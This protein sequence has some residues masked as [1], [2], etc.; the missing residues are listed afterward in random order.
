VA[1]GVALLQAAAALACRIPDVR[2]FPFPPPEVPPPRVDPILTRLHRADI[3]I[4]GDVAKVEVAATFYNPNGFR[5]EG[6]YFFPIEADAVVKDFTM[7]V[8]GKDQKAE[9]LEADR[10]RQIYEDIVRRMKDPGLLEYVGTKMLKARVF[11]IEPRSEIEVRLNYQQVVRAEGGLRHFRY[12]LLSARPN[13][14]SVDQMSVRV[15]VSSESPIKLFYSPSHK[16]DAIRKDDR[17]A[18]GGFEFSSHIPE[19][20]FDLHWS[21]NESDVG[22]SVLAY[23]PRDEDG[24]C[25][26]SLNPKVEVPAGMIQPKDVVFVFDKSG[27]MAGDKMRQAKASLNYCLEKLNKEDR[28]SVILFSTDVDPLTSELV[29]ATPEAIAKAKESVEKADARGGTSI[30]DAL[31]AACKQVADSKRLAMLVFL[32]DGRP[33]VGPS[34]IGDILKAVGAANSGKARMFVFGVGTDLNT[35]LLDRLASEHRGTQTYVT[36]KEDIEVKVSSFFEKVA[37]PVLSDVAVAAGDIE[38]RDLYPRQLP[39]VF[40]GGQLLVFGR[41]R[42][43]GK[44]SVV[45]KGKAA[46]KDQAFECEADFAGAAAND[47]IPSIWAHRKVAFLL[48]EIRTRGHQKELEDEIVALGKRHGILTP[49]TSFL[50]V[51]DEKP[52]PG[53][54]MAPAAARAEGDR[55]ALSVVKSGAEGV[56]LSRGLADARNADLSVGGGAAAPFLGYATH[57]EKADELRERRQVAGERVKRIADKVF[58]LKPDGL[59]YDSAYD[60]KDAGKVVEVAYFSDAYFGLL[61][62]HPGIGRYLSAKLPIVLCLD[63][64][65]YRI[66]E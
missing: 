12:P 11:P 14:G 28:F 6:T 4:A 34:D 62:D 16:I 55:R 38:L 53:R 20:D 24:Y 27:S 36:E 13:A 43:A 58:Y 29:P 40:R 21:V 49:Y 46:G 32:T 30:H 22:V 50:I 18:T 59:Y 35:D 25:L 7:R 31:L 8:N 15:T 41:Y 5:A 48:E 66:K 10:A 17:S 26:I 64:R 61:K 54:P 44:R 65:I 63:G 57:G 52:V 42:G 19:K 60:E 51:E 9:L 2:P 33:T 45:V 1:T 56:A 47:F 39:D 23:K 37:M 3:K